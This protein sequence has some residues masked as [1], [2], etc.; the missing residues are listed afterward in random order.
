MAIIENHSIV[1]AT[2]KDIDSLARLIRSSFADVARRFAL[3]P[4]N[5]PRHPS[6]YTREW[7]EGDM[8]R[9]VRY[10]LLTVEG[11]AV[12]CVGVEQASPT[13]CYME[14]LAVFP[15]H[16]G[17]GYGSRLARHA[18]YQ[19]KVMGAST[20]GIGII[21]ADTGLKNLYKDLG[22]ERGETKSFP[23]LPFK[24]AFMQILV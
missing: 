2:K 1:A 14:R 3:T 7:V 4:E 12:G 19:A 21:A 16:R 24:V 6:N 20:V 18:I 22:F 11:T 5:C 10:Y 23:H 8:G 9:G 13:T 17:K 15:E